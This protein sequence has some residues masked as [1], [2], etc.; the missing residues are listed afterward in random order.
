MLIC[1]TLQTL[2][3]LVFGLKLHESIP[4]LFVFLLLGLECRLYL[5]ELRHD[6]IFFFFEGIHLL[7]ILLESLILHGQVFES[8]THLGQLLL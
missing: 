7:Q 1:V 3:F 2:Q 6:Y 5:L 4:Q 8:V